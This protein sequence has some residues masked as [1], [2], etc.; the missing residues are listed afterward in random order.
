MEPEH[1]T[2]R[3]LGAIDVQ[4]AITGHK[5]I[6]RPDIGRRAVVGK[7]RSVGQPEVDA[8]FA[9]AVAP[10]GNQGRRAKRPALFGVIDRVRAALGCGNSRSPR[11]RLSCGSWTN[12]RLEIDAGRGQHHR[13]WV[14]QQQLVNHALPMIE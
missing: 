8:V 9:D 5:D 4:H 7:R 10:A 12:V 11:E 2:A 13:K 3:L 14:K 6:E 1:L